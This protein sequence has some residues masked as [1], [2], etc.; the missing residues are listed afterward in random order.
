MNFR[1]YVLPQHIF[2]FELFAVRRTPLVRAHSQT[3]KVRCLH[4][5]VGPSDIRRDPLFASLSYS[6]QTTESG[7][8]TAESETYSANA[9]YLSALLSIQSDISI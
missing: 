6:H 4:H 1:M 8:S 2:S 3:G 5:T 7:H 9:T